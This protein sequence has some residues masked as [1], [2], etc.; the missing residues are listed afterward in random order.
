MLRRWLFMAMVGIYTMGCTASVTLKPDPMASAGD[1]TTIIDGKILRTQDGIMYVQPDDGDTVEIP[2]LQIDDIDHPGNGLIVTGGILA[3]LGVLY[4]L[5]FTTAD[6]KLDATPGLLFGLLLT[7]TGSLMGT[8]GWALWIRS[9]AAAG[10]WTSDDE[11]GI[12]VPVQERGF[13][14]SVSF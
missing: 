10:S 7:S 2:V 8:S 14:V 3:L 6:D 5:D 1:S 12:F 13:G 9:R 4:I 11:L